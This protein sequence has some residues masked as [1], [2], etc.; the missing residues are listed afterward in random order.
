M[1]PVK[2]F[3][4]KPVLPKQL[5][6]L[7]ELAYNL[8]WA[9]N[10]DVLS[11]FRR[12]DPELWEKSGHNPVYLLG[13]IDQSK[14]QAAVKN[15][16][17]KTHLEKVVTGYQ[18]Y[19]KKKTTWY[20]QIH[21]DSSKPLTA[22]FSAEFGLTECLSIF[23][24]GLGVLAGDH[25]KSASDLGIPLIGVG[26]LYQQGYFRQQLN[27][28]GVQLEIYEDNDFH[29]LPITRE[30]D[31]NGAPFMVQIDFPHETIHA[32]IWKAQVGRVPLYLLDT[33]V[34]ENSPEAKKITYQLYGGDLEMR[35]R[36][37]IVL[38]IGGYRALR[39]L[40]KSP[41]IYHINEGHSAFLALEHIIHLMNHF[42][43]SFS[44]AK[45]A[46]KA[47]TVFTTH[48]PVPAGHDYFPPEMM[49]QY[50]HQHLDENRIDFDLFLSMG[51]Q[52]F[53]D[54]RHS[55]CMTVFALHMASRSNGVS[56]LHGRVSRKMWQKLYEK[57]PVDE[58]PIEHVTNG[59]HFPSWI[60]HD[61][62]DLY[63]RYLG[64]RWREEPA[65]KSVW[66]KSENIPTE[67][68]W[69]THERRRERLVVFTRNR[70]RDQLVRRGANQTEI[71]FADAVLDTEALTIGFARRF[72][73]Y[74]RASLILQDERRL[75]KL[76]ND[77][78]R[79]MQI[80]FSG[81]AH[82]KDE[83]GQ[84]LI[85]RIVQLANQEQFRR[86][87]VFIEDYDMTVARY[88]VQGADV[89][90]N[91]PLRPR[92]ASGTSGMK[93]AANG[94]LNLSILD[95]WWDEAYTPDVG[96]AFGGKENYEN[97]ETQ[98]QI[99]AEA[100]YTL[101]EQEV[102]PTYYDR[103]IGGLPRKWI[104]KMK[105]SIGALSYFFNT[106]RMVSDYTEKYYNLGQKRSAEM[107][108]NNY[109][110]AKNLARWKEKI[111]AN[112]DKIAIL[113]C[114]KGPENNLHVGDKFSVNVY[115]QLGDLTPKD[116]SVQLYLGRIDSDSNFVD[117]RAIDMSAGT[118]REDG[119]VEYIARNVTCAHSGQHGY[120]VRV[121]PNHKHL[122]V[123]YLPGFIVWAKR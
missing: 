102:L 114:C 93:A 84:E 55:F 42:K 81:K 21:G 65:D 98:D 12:L 61:M 91:N 49:Q 69:R 75:A 34:P 112:W 25:L 96:W 80:I 90:L 35:L 14:L 33:N 18:Q 17:F 22:Y 92:E 89:W 54:N 57:V 77:P 104:A 47:A 63:D 43:L 30:M 83:P 27:A 116:V 95:G 86:R 56:K 6:I 28:G 50:F 121:L 9:W 88:M 97:R 118:P 103:A 106:H 107:A 46:A 73:T 101:L 13:N 45:E 71:D 117:A 4:T 52:S 26:L 79:P 111:S 59:I 119:A 99:E 10:F 36:Q 72:A 37:E 110:A 82:P 23:A 62:K 44:E 60:S 76:L 100:L 58:I 48:T 53:G 51:R 2:T 5:S 74:K 67:E 32:Q 8:Y 19:K 115:V 38:G 24:G 105:K 29:N 1:K 16:G 64:E 123:P 94:V 120:T 31:E 68:L 41:K 20:H 66:Q 109:A 87:I 85:K 113:E 78:E 15:E 11:L 7:S 39:L 108:K 40:K 122:A 3:I 70:L